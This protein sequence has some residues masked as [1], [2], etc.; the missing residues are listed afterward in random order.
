MDSID[1]ILAAGSSVQWT[2]E[3]AE[4]DDLEALHGFPQVSILFE[5]KQA[6]FSNHVSNNCSSMFA[7]SSVSCA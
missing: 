3:E 7:D 4:I 1:N 6:G 2:T 5:V